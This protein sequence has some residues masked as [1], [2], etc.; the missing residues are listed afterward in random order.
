NIRRENVLKNEEIVTQITV[1][2]SP[3]AKRSTYLKFKERDS[4]DFAISAVAI[5]A[6]VDPSKTIKDVRIVLGGVAPMPWRVPAAEKFVTGKK[7]DTEVLNEAARLALADAKPLAKNEYK[8]PLTQTLV[9][10]ALL[11]ATA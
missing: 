10:R 3:L 6:Q 9:R 1:P 11:K 4:L 5:A 7:L 2:A 8:V